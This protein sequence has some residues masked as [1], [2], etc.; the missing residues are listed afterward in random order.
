MDYNQ[1]PL[2]F[3]IVT[4]SHF[5]SDIKGGVVINQN[6]Q[7]PNKLRCTRNGR[8]GWFMSPLPSGK[9]KGVQNSGTSEPDRR[10]ASIH[11]S[12]P[13]RRRIQ[14]QPPRITTFLYLRRQVKTSPFS[15]G[16]RLVPFSFSRRLRPRSTRATP[17][18]RGSRRAR[19]PRTSSSSPTPIRWPAR[20]RRRAP[21]GRPSCRS[22]TT[23]GR[24]PAPARGAAGRRRRT[25]RARPP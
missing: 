14:A 19:S 3:F 7:A 25:L 22:P 4:T 5:I 21:A 12:R 8:E 9:P 13:R 16:H 17:W 23:C 11:R 2:V 6:L 10:K 24:R 15:P 20:P 1:L 18:C